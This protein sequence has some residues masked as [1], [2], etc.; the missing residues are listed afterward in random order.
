MSLS[1]LFQWWIDVE[2]RV[3]EEETSSQA[4]VTDLQKVEDYPR[5]QAT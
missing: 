1:I 2:K 4:S 5:E 3:E